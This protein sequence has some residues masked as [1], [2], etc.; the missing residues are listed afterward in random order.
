MKHKHPKP[1]PDSLYKNETE[2]LAAPGDIYRHYKGG[3]YREFFLATVASDLK[4][5]DEVVVYE[6]LYPNEHGFFV[7]S[8]TE[9]SGNVVKTDCS[10]PRFRFVPKNQWPGY[11]V[12]RFDCSCHSDEHSFALKYDKDEI[13]P[14]VYMTPYL[15]TDENFFQRIWY[16]LKYIFTNKQGKGGYVETHLKEPDIL[17]MRDVLNTALKDMADRDFRGRF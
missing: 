3:I 2:A 11:N 13:F 7:R 9:F 1:H 12:S 8:D 6:H 4:E 14:T 10:Q 17:K 16:A 5:G 15:H